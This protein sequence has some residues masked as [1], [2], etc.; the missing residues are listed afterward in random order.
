MTTDHH[1][2][3]SRQFGVMAAS[4]E[5][6]PYSR[7][8]QPLSRHSR[9]LDVSMDHSLD[10]L[11]AEE[12]VGFEE[13]EGRSGRCSSPLIGV[14]CIFPQ[15][16][17]GSISKKIT[18]L[19]NAAT[20]IASL[21]D[22]VVTRSFR[23]LIEANDHRRDSS[24]LSLAAQPGAAI[25]NAVLDDLDASAVAKELISAQ[26][27]NSWDESALAPWEMVK[28]VPWRT[29]KSIYQKGDLIS[30]ESE[31]S[32]E[33]GDSSLPGGRSD[34]PTE[35]RKNTGFLSA[36]QYECHGMLILFNHQSEECYHKECQRAL[37]L[38]DYVLTPYLHKV[39][40]DQYQQRHIV[41]IGAT[42]I[43]HPA[44][45]QADLQ[46]QIKLLH[47]SLDVIASHLFLL[48]SLEGIRAL[49]VRDAAKLLEP[50]SNRDIELILERMSRRRME[51]L[52]GLEHSWQLNSERYRDDRLRDITETTLDVSGRWHNMLADIQGME[53][54]ASSVAE[55]SRY[56]LPR[57]PLPVEG[58]PQAFTQE[59]T[60]FFGGLSWSGFAE[61]CRSS[62]EGTASDGNEADS[63]QL[64]SRARLVEIH[65]FANR[66]L[67]L[68]TI[69]T[70]ITTSAL[71]T[72]T[73]GLLLGLILSDPDGLQAPYDVLLLLISTFA[74]FFET[75]MLS[76]ASRTLESTTMEV[77]VNSQRATGISLFLGQY[78][79]AV[80]LPL[81]ISRLIG[82]DD[83][84]GEGLFLSVVVCLL[85]LVL[86]IVYF[87]VIK[88]GSF[89]VRSYPRAL[90]PDELD[91]PEHNYYIF[92]TRTRLVLMGGL[93]TLTAGLLMGRLW[94][95][96][97][98]WMW[99][100]ESLLIGS[101]LLMAYMSWLV[102]RVERHFYY[103]ID[104]WD[105]MGVEEASFVD[106]N[107]RAEKPEEK[108]Q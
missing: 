57:R 39:G 15:S 103:K 65:P 47:L 74:F 56:R 31:D 54:V 104:S 106:S 80:A 14:S 66:K 102:A 43:G 9:S 95:I 45:I 46:R 82:G 28:S 63:V 30:L 98:W 83:P 64:E 69:T 24:W 17:G 68:G 36:V 21:S 96:S 22:L 70:R 1:H 6:N 25:T 26:K 44:R 67:I 8:G 101:L 50:T 13:R 75:L 51:S 78:P 94:G 92:P 34:Q 58:F 32:M 20:R 52:I 77:A 27:N 107:W 40:D 12:R 11:Q 99:T 108:P 81:T 84:T 38:D 41:T 79:F 35:M 72:A 93:H 53:E 55:C 3:L 10:P 37:T 33:P 91:N 61:L 90:E 100:V 97:Y 89:T 16:R 73:A 48:A 60:D 86:L 76:Y 5:W 71:L 29:V 42:S 88:A 18:L 4:A 7:Y 62:R 19:G 2:V 49:F 105:G 23:L 85:A 59:S 87:E